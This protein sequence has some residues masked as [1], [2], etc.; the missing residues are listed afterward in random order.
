MVAPFPLSIIILTSDAQT[1]KFPVDDQSSPYTGCSIG[2]EAIP[3][4]NGD[5]PYFDR[6]RYPFSALVLDP[7]PNI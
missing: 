1:D 4:P 2:M 5:P 3:F 7:N 6:A